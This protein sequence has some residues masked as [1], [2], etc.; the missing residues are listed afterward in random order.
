MSKPKPVQALSGTARVV[1]K[2]RI[3]SRPTDVASDVTYENERGSSVDW[4]V[5]FSKKALLPT[6]SPPWSSESGALKDDIRQTTC[7]KGWE[8]AS[9]W[10]VDMNGD[11]DS[12]GWSYGSQFSA[13]KWQGS[14]TLGLYVR[15]RRWIRTRRLISP[16]S[17]NAIPAGGELGPTSSTK[18][19][20]Q[21]SRYRLDSEKLR[22]LEE[23]VSQ[24]LQMTP[25]SSKEVKYRL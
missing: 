9:N 11:L 17:T 25:I 8:W 13:D 19:V 4:S 12:D 1:N 5:H 24:L 23:T 20:S 18:L 7:P 16:S 21:L 10:I 6:D 2:A 3:L 14:C 22:S 15:R